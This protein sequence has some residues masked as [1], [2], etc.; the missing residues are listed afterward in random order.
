MGALSRRSAGWLARRRG[1]DF[2]GV[3]ENGT[4]GSAAVRSDASYPPV[5][6]AVGREQFFPWINGPACLVEPAGAFVSNPNIAHL[7]FGVMVYIPHHHLGPAKGVD[8]DGGIAGERNVVP[9]AKPQALEHGIDDVTRVFSNRDAYVDPLHREETLA[10]SWDYGRP[11]LH[12]NEG[13]RPLRWNLG[14]RRRIRHNA[15][16]GPTYE[17]QQID[18]G[19]AFQQPPT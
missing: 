17:A 16:N 8:A 4:A 15:R 14:P 18:A 12:F 10:R 19:V 6:V 9:V 3:A 13:T 1:V 5:Y 11:N 7:F 2:L